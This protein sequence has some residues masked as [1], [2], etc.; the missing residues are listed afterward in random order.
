[1]GAY[2]TGQ[3]TLIHGH[4][5][6][7]VCSTAGVRPPPR[8]SWGCGATAAGA[9]PVPGKCRSRRCGAC[10]SSPFASGPRPPSAPARNALAQ[11]RDR[12]GAGPPSSAPHFSVSHVWLL[13]PR[14]SGPLTPSASPRF[15]RW[16]PA[17]ESACRYRRA[18]AVRPPGCRRWP[19]T[20][21][22]WVSR[23]PTGT[24]ASAPGPKLDRD[25]RADRRLRSSRVGHRRP[26]HHRRREGAVMATQPHH[27][28]R[29]AGH[30][31]RTGLPDPGTESPG[32]IP[33]LITD[34]CRTW[35]YADLRPVVGVGGLAAVDSGRW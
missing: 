27:R 29:Q 6:A 15:G 25:L 20:P 23:S 14:W 19:P 30:H 32:R 13:P 1:M 34:L 5:G 33:L 10:R 9:G 21:G 16:C 3:T 24:P 31:R 22:S 4:H 8:S 12:S 2:S 7:G 11:V 35:N 26:R 18:P 17:A 28:A